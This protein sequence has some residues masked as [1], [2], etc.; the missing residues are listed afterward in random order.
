[1]SITAQQF[2]EFFRLNGLIRLDDLPDPEPVLIRKLPVNS[3]LHFL[4][5][6][7]NPSIDPSDPLM[8][9]YTDRVRYMNVTQ[10]PEGVL[11]GRRHVIDMNTVYNSFDRTNRNF[12]VI[13]SIPDMAI[14]GAKQLLVVNYGYLD[15]AYVW[16][17]VAT[18]RFLKFENKLKTMVS[19]IKQ[20]QEKS[21]RQHFIVLDVPPMLLPKSVLDRESL[22]PVEK[23]RNFF[24]SGDEQ[25]LRHLWLF[26]NSTDTGEVDSSESPNVVKRKVSAESIFSEFS[27]DLKRNVNFLYKSYDGKYTVVNLGYLHSWVRGNSNL[28]FM[29]SV[30]VKG[31]EDV[32]KYM[33]RGLLVLQTINQSGASEKAKEE[34]QRQKLAEVEAQQKLSDLA[35]TGGEGA[36]DKDER[37]LQDREY[38][39][40]AIR[41]QSGLSEASPVIGGDARKPTEQVSSQFDSSVKTKDIKDEPAVNEEDVNKDLDALEKVYLKQMKA[42][43]DAAAKA[44]KATTVDEAKITDVVP[45]EGYSSEVVESTEEIKAQLFKTVTPQESLFK[46]LDAMVDEGR[47]T[48][49]EYRKKA[50]LIK[51]APNLPDPYGS[52]KTIAQASVVTKEE[53]TITKEEAALN[54]PAAVIDK[55]MAESTLNVMARKYNTETI[56]KDMLSCVQAVQKGDIII[57]DHMVTTQHTALGSYDLHTLEISALGGMPSLVRAKIPRIHEDGHFVAK[58]N[59]YVMRK[60]MVDLPIRKIGANRVGLS[61][62][63]GKTFVDRAVKKADSSLDYV[64]TR[65]SKATIQ[66]DEYLRDVIP[67]D[68]FD[69]Y[70]ESPYFFSGISEKFKSFRAGDITFDM[71]YK[72]FRKT[73]DPKI[74]DFLEKDGTRICGWIAGGKKAIITIDKDS[75][76]FANRQGEREPLGDIFDILRMDRANAPVDFAEVKVFAQGIP[77]GVYYGQQIGF[78]KLVKMLQAKHRLVEGRQQKNLQPFEYV[79]QF[80][81]VAYI[82]DRREE[83]NALVLAGFQAFHKETKL[84]DAEL[85]DAKDVYLRLLET[86]GLSSI[87][88]TEMENMNNMFVDPITE[89]ILKEMNEPTSFNELLIRSCELLKTYYYPASQD[90]NYQRIRGYDRFA[91]FFYKELVQAVRGYKARNRTGRAKVD[92]S[93]YQVWTT[94]TRDSAVKHAED[95]NPIQSVKIAQEAVTYV[96]EGGRGK[97]SM[98][99]QSRAYMTSNL[100]TLSEASVDSSDVGINAFLSAVPGFANTDG[101]NKKDRPLGAA[102]LLSTSVLLAPYS[103]NDD[104]KRKSFIS[105]QQ[106]HTI[107]TEGYGAPMVRSGYESVLGM[108][109]SEMFAKTAPQDG[110]VSSISE[111]GITVKFKDGTEQ[112][113]PLG[114]MFGKAE[115]SVYPHNLI[116]PLKVGQKFKKDEY[117]TYN[118]N[119]FEPDPILPGGIV[120]KGSLM[121]RMVLM[122]VPQ[123]HEDSSTISRELSERLKTTTTKVKTYTVGFKQNIHDIV[124]VGQRLKPEDILMTIE[125]EIT[126]S[127]GSFRDSSLAIL[128]ERSKNYP[129]SGYIGTVSHVEVFYHGDVLNMSSTLKSIAQKSD[130]IKA[131]EGKSRLQ[132]FST[133]FVDGDFSVD[134]TPLALGKAV[135][136]IYINVGDNASTGDKIVLGHQLKSVIG[137]VMP[138]TL[139][140]ENGDKIDVK[141]GSRSYAARIV[142]SIVKIGEKSTT[143]DV[144]G[145]KQ[146]DIY[147]S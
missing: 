103:E 15:E 127:D 37:F 96:G 116:T 65:L 104:Q 110:Q 124:K 32:Q 114:M 68:V 100:G 62:Y 111:R 53:L 35:L 75:F 67:G 89:R 44:K 99:R 72:G 95:N 135:I 17:E 87:Y 145:Q 52:G 69:N 80:R 66:P 121:C 19:T 138:Y 97:E 82:F 79:V 43:D 7:D 38:E 109:T 147:Y 60:Q 57:K 131:E 30:V 26:L 63:Y 71:N 102:N 12:K 21:T 141:M 92:M 81:D 9:G 129:K 130:R 50:E 58:G 31:Y 40:S 133:G 107:A 42:I 28:T 101:L 94:I 3:A 126:A 132:P 4:G 45:V 46:R 78:R 136:K 33:L 134:G 123:T 27:D 119:F 118:T 51:A 18:S 85:F 1:M 105:I 83:V 115:G 2:P 23:L 22:K 39:T 122:E 137:E 88:M 20:M 77:V 54:V 47:I 29:K 140:T 117:I 10:Y 56:Y 48:A 146:Y 14:V 76:F 61:S 128:S 55:S 142:E 139:R 5:N 143:L 25:I 59:K 144:M 74:V 6:D 108:R 86:K 93:P 98:N 106:G 84:F 16:A 24:R 13:K 49:S 11:G 64:L 73:L 34:A 70:F 90:A 41:D 8:L 91:G 120:Y 112:G 113:Y 125:D 36:S